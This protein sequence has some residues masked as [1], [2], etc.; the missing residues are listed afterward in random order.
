[1]AKVGVGRYR[2]RWSK[3]GLVSGNKT[4][5]VNRFAAVPL[6]EGPWTPVWSLTVR[7]WSKPSGRSF[8]RPDQTET[9]GGGHCRAGGGG[10]HIKMPLMEDEEA[11]MPSAG[12]LNAIFLSCGRSNA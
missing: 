12:K 3:G 11:A 9:S 2:G 1:M 7:R 5:Q 4:F 8:D 10:A 6:D